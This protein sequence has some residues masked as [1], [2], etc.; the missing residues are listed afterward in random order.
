MTQQ[1][2]LRFDRAQG[3]IY[4]LA[5]LFLA[6]PFMDFIMNVWPLQLDKVNWRYGA[7]GLAGGFLLTPLLGLVMLL[8]T[9]ILYDNR[10]T[11]TVTAV[12]SSIVALA[13]ILLSMA[14]VLDS[15][16]MRSGVPVDQKRVFDAGVLKALV[17][18]ATGAICAAWVAFAAMRSRSGV[19]APSKR[20][21]SALVVGRAEKAG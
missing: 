7:F 15:L 17:K 11:L 5:F 20:D 8:V 18:D 1:T 12:I 2:S 4:F 9:A 13:L 21:R 16:Q 19:S 3:P 10:R 6:L 14:F